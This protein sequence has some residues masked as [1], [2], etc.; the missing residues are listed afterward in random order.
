MKALLNSLRGF[1]LTGVM[2]LAALWAGYKLWDYYFNAPWTR[3]GHVRADVVPVAPDV[4]GFV[5]EVL[6]R[7]NEQVRRG[8]V[9]F[10]IDGH[11][12]PSHWNRPRR[13]WTPDVPRSTTRMPT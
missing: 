3:D 8:D 4:S 9:L 13:C 1:S 6:V 2:V 10:R 7:D 5:S 12:T 11:G